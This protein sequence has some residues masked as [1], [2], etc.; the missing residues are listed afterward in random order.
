MRFVTLFV[1]LFLAV[2]AWAG[3]IAVVDFQR[4]VQET[5]EG[6]SAQ[7]QL[8]G[9]YESRKTELENMQVQL[10]KELKDLEARAVMLSE[11]AKRRAMADLQ[12]KNADFQQKYMQYQQEFQQQYAALLQGLDTKMR[13]VTQT[14]A[15]E[16]GYDIVIDK[17]A[18][19]YAGPGVT[20]MTDILIQR[21]NAG[22]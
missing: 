12:Q 6:K 10:E 20:D 1:A 2:P 21:Y 17:A 13:T 8:E 4:A 16:K 11:E 15:K 18:A 3:G 19:V 22:G 5:N 7:R 14:I 9:M